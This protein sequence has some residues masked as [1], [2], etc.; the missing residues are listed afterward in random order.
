MPPLLEVSNLSLHIH[1]HQLL[2]AISFAMYPEEIVG[3][4]GGSGCGKSLMVSTILGLNPPSHHCQG[5]VTFEGQNLW[6]QKIL[7][8]RLSLILQDPSLALD[9]LMP[10][11]RQLIEGL[12]YHK[13]MS[14]SAAFQQGIEWL[15]RV[16][17]SDPQLR[18]SQYPHEISGGMK[19]RIV[20][21]MALICGPS[22]LIADEPTTALDVTMQLQILELL[23]Q[24]KMSILLITHDLGVVARYCQRALVMQAGQ[25]VETGS[26]EQ[27]FTSPQ[28]PYTQALLQSKQWI[29]SCPY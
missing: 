22:L 10:V 17:I 14:Y 25:I 9:P 23:Q 4:I 5:Q 13:R 11:G 19:Q 6:Q 29:Q 2:H 12:R 18:M 24:Q 8:T 20:I 27:I 28:H 16:G 15:A 26:V 3:L 1:D 7:G 21:A